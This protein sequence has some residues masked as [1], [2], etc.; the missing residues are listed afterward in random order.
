MKMM[1]VLWTPQQKND[2]FL[3][4][5]LLILFDLMLQYI[6]F[7]IFVEDLVEAV[8][9]ICETVM[10]AILSVRAAISY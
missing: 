8:L 10:E 9:F 4:V 6:C 3:E 7:K 5:H 1:R 2:Q